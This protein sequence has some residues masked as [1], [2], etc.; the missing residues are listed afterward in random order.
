MARPDP[1]SHP[2]HPIQIV[3]WFYQL[4]QSFVAYLFAPPTPDRQ[5]RQ[6]PLG[7]I[8]VIG[9][10]VSGL[11]SAAHFVGHGFD[12]VIFEEASELGGIWGKKRVNSTSGLQLNSLMYRFF[13][14][15]MYTHSYPKRDEILDNLEQVWKNYGLDKKTRFHHK[16][17]SVT[18]HKSSTDPREGG[19]A[20]WIVN[21]NEGE[22][23]DAVVATVGTCGAPHKMEL[24]GQDKFKGKIVHSSELDDVEL[25]GKR[26]IVVG[27]GASGIEA[28]ELAVEKKAKSAVILA[29]SDKW[30]IPRSTIIDIILALNPFG[31]QGILMGPFAQFFLRKL[32]YRDLEEKMAP[33]NVPLFAGTPI[34]N[35]SALTHIRQGK[36]DYQRGDLLEVKEHGVLFNKR[37]KTQK[38]GEEG[39]H[40]EYDADVIVVATGFD[41]PTLD[42]L[43]KDL[44]PPDYVPPS[45]YLQVFPV[46]DPSVLLTNATYKNAIGTVGNWHIGIYARIAMVLLMD[47]RCRPHPRNMRLWTDLIRF[48]KEKSPA[49]GL[50]FFTY[51]ELIIWLV[52]FIF[53]VPRRT[54][55]FFFILFGYGFWERSTS[56]V[57]K[58]G[59]ALG[60]PSFHLS[61]SKLIPFRRH[62]ARMAIQAP[63]SIEEAHN[64]VE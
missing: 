58:K 9:A 38:K 11:S 25:R 27:G 57:D 30:I 33:Y 42:F 63:N 60:E 52:G 21:G 43:P 64:K 35:N 12:V 20:R 37:G 3:V 49:P 23:F 17:T 36:A 2:V 48:I 31:R 7:H 45:C 4:Y 19:H 15:C 44:F 26:V 53:V 56:K 28:L 10:G 5:F 40:V 46:E 47:E 39:E 24:K 54:R 13:P 41:R 29:R 16:V 62:Q 50:T 32:H 1:N 14:T 8:A 51:T 34:V 6:K 22:I 59:R 18:R 55:Y 61:T